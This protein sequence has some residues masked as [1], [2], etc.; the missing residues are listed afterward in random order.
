MSAYQ[1]SR[2]PDLPAEFE[3]EKGDQFTER[4]FAHCG[5]DDKWTIIE[6]LWE[7]GNE[8]RPTRAHHRHYRLINRGTLETI[9][10]SEWDLL[11]DGWIQIKE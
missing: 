8:N 5:E 1:T 10:I 4:M 6:Y 3:F 9:E 11:Y 7:Y 2:R